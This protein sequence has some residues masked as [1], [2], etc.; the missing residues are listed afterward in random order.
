[1]PMPMLIHDLVTRSMAKDWIEKTFY[2]RAKWRLQY[3]W[4]PQGCN[5]TGQWLWLC[6]AYQGEAVWA[7]PEGPVYEFRYHDSTEHIIWLL[8]GKTK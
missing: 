3:L 7:G 1:M 4:W 5:L 6:W 8:K 2:D